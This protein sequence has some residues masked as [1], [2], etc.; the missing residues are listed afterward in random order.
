MRRRAAPRRVGLCFD[1][2]FRGALAI[3]ACVGKDFTAHM[4]WGDPFETQMT[5]VMVFS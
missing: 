5:Q 1:L 4:V 3:V 2:S